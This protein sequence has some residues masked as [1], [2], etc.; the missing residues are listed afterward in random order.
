MMENVVTLLVMR[1]NCDVTYTYVSRLRSNCHTKCDKVVNKYK[2]LGTVL[3]NKITFEIFDK[4]IIKL[5]A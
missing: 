2:Y 5:S 3:D 4:N 1:K